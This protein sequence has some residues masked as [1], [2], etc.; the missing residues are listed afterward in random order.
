MLLTFSVLFVQ[1]W[2]NLL[3]DPETTEYSIVILDLTTKN[4][5]VEGSAPCKQITTKI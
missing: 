5:I 1:G 3:G 2:I 4:K